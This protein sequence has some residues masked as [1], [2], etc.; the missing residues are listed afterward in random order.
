SP[1]QWGIPRLKSVL[2]S[3]PRQPEVAMRVRL[4][5]TRR[6]PTVTRIL[7]DTPQRGHRDSRQRRTIRTQHRARQQSLRIQPKL[8][9]RA[10]LSSLEIEVAPLQHLRS[11]R[12]TRLGDQNIRAARRVLVE[13]ELAVMVCQDRP[14][15]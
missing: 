9:R 1:I 13:S 11:G 10:Q 7:P 12:E 4:I 14:V 6:Y 15:V 3:R 5:L 2:P 8:Q